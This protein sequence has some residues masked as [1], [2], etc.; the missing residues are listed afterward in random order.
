MIRRSR[1]TVA[2]LLLVAIASCV[3]AG[4]PQEPTPPTM[5]DES[6]AIDK[7]EHARISNALKAQS[8]SSGDAT[9]RDQSKDAVWYGIDFAR[10]LAPHVSRIVGG[11]V[12]GSSVTIDGIRGGRLPPPPNGDEE[13]VLKPTG[14]WTRISYTPRWGSWGT[15]GE[16]DFLTLATG[17]IGRKE[18]VAM[19]RRISKEIAG[20]LQLGPAAEP[21]VLYGEWTLVIRTSTD[22]KDGKAASD[23]VKYIMVNT[24][25]P[26]VT[27]SMAFDREA[28]KT[29]RSA[30]PL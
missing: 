26:N 11:D 28:L 7:A 9:T 30:I 19:V 1:T 17:D 12:D 5:T 10:P 2:V 22:P 3:A 13:L 25:G 27:M 15:Y 18:A 8:L 4:D 21:I 20:R 24:R 14:P 6:F 29:R 16:C 23:I